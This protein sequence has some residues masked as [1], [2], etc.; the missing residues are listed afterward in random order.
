MFKLYVDRFYPLLW[1]SEIKTQGDYKTMFSYKIY[2]N[3]FCI[4]KC[5]NDCVY[6]FYS[7]NI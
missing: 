7:E 3:S 2:M 5:G 1:F 6:D 4:D